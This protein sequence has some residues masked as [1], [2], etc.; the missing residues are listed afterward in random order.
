MLDSRFSTIQE[1]SSL[2]IRVAIEKGW[3]KV[4]GKY[5]QSLKGMMYGREGNA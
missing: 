5:V 3:N 4:L 1:M 2:E